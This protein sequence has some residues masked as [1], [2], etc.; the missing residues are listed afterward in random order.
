MAASWLTAVVHISQASLTS[1][2]TGRGDE[3]CIKMVTI[4]GY[5]F[6]KKIVLENVSVFFV[7]CFL[8]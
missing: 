5:Y 6:L 2:W 7:F 8:I 3:V 4:N 1:C